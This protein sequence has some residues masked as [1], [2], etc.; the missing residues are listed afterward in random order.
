MRALL[1]VSDLTGLPAFASGLRDLGWELFATDGTRRALRSEGVDARP[2]SDLTGSESL[3]DGRVKTLHPQLHAAI[4][5]RR[6]KPEHLVELREHGI[7]PI[8]LVVVNLYRFADAVRAGLRGSELIDQIDIGGVALLRAAAKN[9]DGVVVIA[10]SDRFPTVLEE[11]RASGTVSHDLRSRLAAEAFAH[12]AAYDA[13]I[14][15]QLNAELGTLF[16]DEMSIALAKVRDLRYGENPHQSAAFYAVR[17][18]EGVTTNLVQLHGRQT[19]FNNLLDL[20]SAWTI[21]NDFPQPTVA[22]VKYQNPCGIASHDNVAQAYRSAFACDTVSAFGGI[23]GVN[24]PVTT[25]FAEA[26]RETFY[27]AII[28]PEYE[29]RALELLRER[30]NLEILQAAGEAARRRRAFGRFDFK[31][32]SGGVLVQTPDETLED[33]SNFRVVTERHPTLDELTD[34]LFAWRCVRH[35][36]SVGIVFAKGLA[37]VGIGPGQISRVVAVEVAAR[38]AGERA[39]LSVMASDAYFPFP[40]GIE[41]AA[42]AGVTAIIQP[43]GSVRDQMMI[44][45]ANRHRMAMWFTGRRHF[46]H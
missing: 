29:E 8:D 5:A 17:G 24:R 27:E 23:V 13:Q 16:P 19:S 20:D 21:A 42:R 30:R 22:I 41:V 39:R 12:T 38:K 18:E 14:A 46:R 7:E 15:S 1:S 40:D 28:A 2:I 11:L 44:D 43:G 31:R 32:V 6:D 35:V 4:L 45:T 3:L 25:A 33:Q 10:R 34:L 9:H 37:T 36:K 26:M